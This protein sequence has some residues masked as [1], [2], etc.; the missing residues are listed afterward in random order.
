MNRI[1]QLLLKNNFYFKHWS[2]EKNSEND[3]ID[4]RNNKKQKFENIT[5]LTS[6]L[7]CSLEQFKEEKISV[8]NSSSQF[9]IEEFKKMSKDELN[10]KSRELNKNYIYT[11]EQLQ[12]LGIL[13][14]DLSSD[15]SPYKVIETYDGTKLYQLK[16]RAEQANGLL[17]DDFTVNTLTALLPYILMDYD[18]RNNTQL[19]DDDTLQN[20]LNE[21]VKNRTNIKHDYFELIQLLHGNHNKIIEKFIISKIQNIY[22]DFKYKFHELYKKYKQQLNEQPEQPEQPEQLKLSEELKIKFKNEFKNL[23]NYLLDI[24]DLLKSDIDNY[25]LN[26]EP[27]KEADKFIMNLQIDEL[28]ANIK[29]F[30]DNDNNNPF[31]DL[32][33]KNILFCYLHVAIETVKDI[34]NYEK[35]T[36]ILE[37]CLKEISKPDGSNSDGTKSD[38]LK[39]D[40]KKSD[41]SKSSQNSSKSKKVP[42]N[43]EINNELYM[44]EAAAAATTKNLIDIDQKTQIGGGELQDDELHKK[45]LKNIKDN[46]INKLLLDNFIIKNN[47]IKNKG[48]FNNLIHHMNSYINELTYEYIEKKANINNYIPIYMYINRVIYNLKNFFQI[49]SYFI[50]KNESN[51]KEILKTFFLKNGELL[52]HFDKIL[53]NSNLSKF[54]V[55]EVLFKYDSN[56]LNHDIK[57][58]T[59]TSI[60]KLKK[61]LIEHSSQ[62]MQ[63]T[64]LINTKPTAVDSTSLD[65]IRMPVKTEMTGGGLNAV[66]EVAREK[67]KKRSEKNLERAERAAAEKNVAAAEEAAVM[68]NAAEKK[69]R[70]ELSKHQTAAFM[71][72]AA[73]NHKAAAEVADARK[74]GISLVNNVPDHL[75]EEAAAEAE[76]NVAAAEKKAEKEVAAI[77]KM[78]NQQ[79]ERARAAAANEV[80]N[81]QKVAAEKLTTANIKTEAELAA[82]RKREEKATNRPVMNDMAA[83]V[84]EG[85]MQSVDATWKRAVMRGEA[86]ESAAAKKLSLAK[87]R[88]AAAVARRTAAVTPEVEE[89]A[90][91]ARREEETRLANEAGMAKGVGYK[92]SEADED[93]SIYDKIKE[94][95]NKTSSYLKPDDLQEKT[96]ERDEKNKTIDLSTT[97]N[98]KTKL[99]FIVEKFFYF[100]FDNLFVDDSTFKTKIDKLTENQLINLFEP[101]QER[102][103]FSFEKLLNPSIET[104]DFKQIE[105]NIG[106]LESEFSNIKKSL[107]LSDEIIPIINEFDKIN[108]NFINMKVLVLYKKTILKKMITKIKQYYDTIN[109]LKIERVLYIKKYSS[110]DIVTIESKFT[111]DDLLKKYI[112]DFDGVNEP[113]N[114]TLEQLQNIEKNYILSFEHICNS[115]L[116]LFMKEHDNIDEFF[117]N[118]KIS[119]NIKREEYNI[120][121]YNIYMLLYKTINFEEF[122]K[123][124][125]FQQFILEYLAF[126]ISIIKETSTVICNFDNIKEQEGNVLKKITS[127][128]ACYI[129]NKD[130]LYY[131]IN[132]ESAH[133]VEPP[134]VSSPSP[135]PDSPSW[136]EYI[137][138]HLTLRQK[139]VQEMAN[140][141]SNLPYGWYTETH[142]N[143]LKIFYFTDE[144]NNILHTQWEI[145]TKEPDTNAVLP[146]GWHPA[147]T[148]K[149]ER[150]FYN[151]NGSYRSYQRDFPTTSA[152][153][154]HLN[155]ALPPLNVL[156]NLQTSNDKDDETLHAEKNEAASHGKAVKTMVAAS[157]Y[158]PDDSYLVSNQNKITMSKNKEDQ[159]E[160]KADEKSSVGGDDKVMPED[161][162]LFL[163]SRLNDMKFNQD[164]I[165]HVKTKM[166]KKYDTP[167]NKEMVMDN[168]IEIAIN[169]KTK[170][171][172]K[173]RDFFLKLMRN[174]RNHNGN[175]EENDEI[176]KKLTELNLKKNEEHKNTKNDFESLLNSWNLKLEHTP[177]DGNCQFHA[178][179]NEFDKLK[180]VN[181][182]YDRFPANITSADSKDKANYLRK[183]VMD[184]IKKNKD[185]IVYEYSIDGDDGPTT[186]RKLIELSEKVLNGNKGRSINKYIE[187]MEKNPDTENTDQQS[188]GDV[189]TLAFLA[190][191]FNVNIIVFHESID[192]STYPNSVS[193][194]D[195]NNLQML[196]DPN[197]IPDYH[198]I[199]QTIILAHINGN[200]FA[201]VKKNH[202]N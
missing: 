116:I 131:F 139:K 100:I 150:F 44:F 17:R 112:F 101:I 146:S 199:I 166:K 33:K 130:K 147:M 12:K 163:D 184:W 113:M 148:P 29:N 193:L 3:Y 160:E 145:P 55:Y 122:K 31:S 125:L 35:K 52:K 181:Q 143:N 138:N 106:I 171:N 183:T 144:N 82:A 136:K 149:Y 191:I 50:K 142:N 13:P 114:I 156:Y 37:N 96:I 129:P 134:P 168:A 75:K 23:L 133:P 63:S 180:K 104:F 57:Y 108:E 176:K 202:E 155:A 119:D 66:I 127:R 174:P 30:I 85:A 92:M 69:A 103:Y 152:A 62:S 7:F 83:A 41:E 47:N 132:F 60:E 27:P 109:Y 51:K 154:L 2:Y 77:N 179:A 111:I 190:T 117:V 192:S 79:A 39:P 169:M 32:N 173:L 40:G 118:F 107:H 198:N 172:K 158:V 115:F 45:I 135:H 34:N 153:A 46:C 91:N 72:K 28:I 201:S 188:W 19:Y 48:Q 140:K 59:E 53:N 74:K 68:V 110:L 99:Y 1:N 159:A 97:E 164:T 187:D 16:S 24:L 64:N 87:D 21:I 11:E 121:K 195:P 71:A 89:A 6:I 194:Y 196:L 128:G 15:L 49:F 42:I 170:D 80:E 18:S 4:Y 20:T 65:R 58:I 81:A 178:I 141:I 90:E 182:I 61:P 102:P 93:N 73:A 161:L 185:K 84:M 54:F 124:I 177:G 10:Q 98:I 105:N 165:E 167:L 76:K 70:R 157:G 137:M 26:L 86:A 126:L 197:D 94:E 162:E 95:K 22:N 175:V 88:A 25:K 200:H 14:P 8:S 151:D 9:D 120:S 38:E 67:S 5:K 43:D 123:N 36:E 186:L 56:D 189:F 78:A